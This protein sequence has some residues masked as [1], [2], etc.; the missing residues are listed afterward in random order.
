[1]LATAT[2][3]CAAVSATPTALGTGRIVVGSRT[4]PVEY[5]YRW[6]PYSFADL[7]GLRAMLTTGVDSS[8]VSAATRISFTRRRTCPVVGWTPGPEGPALVLSITVRNDEKG[9]GRGRLRFRA[10][11]VTCQ[12][13]VAGG[14]MGRGV[15]DGR[16]TTGQVVRLE[17]DPWSAV[18]PFHFSPD[19]F[20]AIGSARP[21]FE[22]TQALCAELGPGPPFGGSAALER[23]TIR[24]DR[25]EGEPLVATWIAAQGG[26]VLVH[27]A[28]LDHEEILVL[29]AFPS[30]GT[31]RGVVALVFHVRGE[32]A[33]AGT[34]QSAGRRR[35]DVEAGRGP[36]S[37]VF[38]LVDKGRRLRRVVPDPLVS[39]GLWAE[40][41]TN[42]GL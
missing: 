30:P 8:P 18:T 39:T 32:G 2:A 7:G 31:N 36:E 37:R 34:L 22:R 10:G 6:V 35:I 14:S 38:W 29:P 13:D 26:K 24:R 27:V 16:C 33:N 23:L 11:R 1:M 4:Y 19:A 41:L 12:A 15:M 9:V 40:N 20:A 17:L 3:A 25:Q 21:D 42:Q 5:V 28:W